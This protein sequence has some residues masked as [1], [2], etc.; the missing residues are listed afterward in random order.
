[1]IAGDSQGRR[2]VIVGVAGQDGSYLAEF[3]ISKGY[4]VHGT[5]RPNGRDVPATLRKEISVVECDLTG[6]DQLRRVIDEAHP[7]EVY[8]LAA[9]HFSSE[10]EGDAVDPFVRVNLSTPV[11]VAEHIAERFPQ[12]RL[13]FAA[14]AHIFGSPAET[15]QDEGT[16]Q[17]PEAPYGITKAACRS[18]LG[19]LRESKGLFAVVGILYNH[20]SVRRG[21]SFVTS[22]I[23]RAAAEAAE[24]RETTLAIRDPEA[25]VDWG[26]AEDYVRAM[27]M[28]MQHHDP[29]DYV[30]ATGIRRRVQDFVDIAFSHVGLDPSDFVTTA[31]GQV[32]TNVPWVGDPSRLRRACG[33]EPMKTF[34]E[35]VHEMVDHYRG[36]LGGPPTTAASKG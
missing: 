7:H 11:R 27:W 14:S 13:F 19:Y 31:L 17:R 33:W 2:A 1:M 25:V 18:L 5:V 36:R 30:I 4:D 32:R 24:G 3:L 20:E 26:A 15:P 8:Y 35:L 10:E 6:D 34:E 23:A 16:P 12:T 21:E 22:Q 9:H 29:S 28:T